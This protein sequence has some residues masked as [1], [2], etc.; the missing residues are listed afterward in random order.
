MWMT[1]VAFREPLLARLHFD[2]YRLGHQARQQAERRDR[3][4]TESVEGINEHVLIVLYIASRNN[5]RT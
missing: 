1:E 3:Y 2:H 5:N 4:E